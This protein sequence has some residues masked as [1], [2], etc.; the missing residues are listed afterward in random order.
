MK[1]FKTL[2]FTILATAVSFSLPSSHRLNDSSVADNTLVEY[3]AKA[4]IPHFFTHALVAYPKLGFDRNNTMCGSY[5]ADCLTVGEFKAI[6]SS[7]YEKGYALVDI[8]ETYDTADG[9]AKRTSFL[10]P[11]NK[12][13]I[14]LS[15][16]DINYYVK[17]MNRGMNDR[18]DADESG[19]IFTYTE[20]ADGQISYD[21]EV[22]TVLENF[23]EAHPDFSYNGARGVLCLT[24]YDGVLG[25]RTDRDS[26]SKE[27][28]TQ[29]AKRVV[30]ALKKRGWRFACH[31]YGHYH[32]KKISARKFREDTDKW[33][34]EVEPIV[35][36]TDI[37]VYPY[38]E[39]E[40]KGEKHDHLEKRGFKL[41]CGVGAKDYYTR[42]NDKVL[43]WDRKPLD[44]YSLRN[45]RKAY[46]PYFDATDF[47]DAS[48]P[49]AFT[50]CD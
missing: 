29:Q 9:Q 45:F 11:E 31:S 6:L 4:E 14:V 38:G 28:D 46:A 13:P 5:D 47:Y 3:S 30:N 24:G 22:V 36:K 42:M 27:Q 35:G 16:D 48:R 2:V 39:W 19:R 8:T 17:K 50:D 21:N 15:F 26:P 49:T 34:Y 37:Y 32:M 33:L 25:Y 18:L 7:L 10:F 40:T 43:F 20:H 1:V 41:F 44:G 23:I 12:K